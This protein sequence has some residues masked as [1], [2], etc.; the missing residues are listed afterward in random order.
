MVRSVNGGEGPRLRLGDV[1][2]VIE[3]AVALCQL[4]PFIHEMAACGGGGI[5]SD[6]GFVGVMMMVKCLILD[7]RVGIRMTYQRGGSS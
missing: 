1:L 4:C 2:P 7:T 5:V 3:V 6:V